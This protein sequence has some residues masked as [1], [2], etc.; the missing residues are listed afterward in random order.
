MFQPVPNQVDFVKQEHEVLDFWKHTDA[1]R[2]LQAKNKG[3][4]RFSFVDGP[5]TANN[6]MGAHHAWG[7]TYKDVFQ[8]YK[9][10]RGFD[11][12]WQNGFDC[13]GLWVEVEV[14]KEQGFKTKRD[15]ET[16]GLAN[17]VNLCKQRVLEYSAVQT[18]Q[19]IRLGYWMD[20]NDTDF[21]RYLKTKMAE[22]PAQVI[23]VDGPN[24]AVTDTVE[25]IVGRLGL[26]ELGGSYFTF[27]NENNYS[28]WTALKQC[29]E[30]GWI[31]KGTDVMPWCARCGTGISQHE[32]ATEGYQELT[33]PS[34]F[35][36][37][38][39]RNRPGEDL[40]VWTTTPWTLSSNVAAAV[41]P[42]LPYVLVEQ[43]PA[44]PI[45]SGA[46]E[47]HRFWLSKRALDNALQGSYTILDEKPGSELEGWTYD[48]P[49][50]ELPAQQASGAVEAHRVVLWDEISEA[51]GTGI[52]HMAPGCGA[53]DYALGRKLGLPAI[54]PLNDAGIFLD[55][56]D[57]LTGMN[58][59]ETA[60]PIFD[61]LKEKGIL[62]RLQD[63][64]HRYPVCWRCQDELVFRLVNEWFIGMG[65]PLDKP[66]E[67]VT[68]DEKADRLRY[69][70]ME[71]V[72]DTRWIPD[73]GFDREM[74]WLRNMHDWM[75]SKKRY[76]GLALPIW[77]CHECGWFDVIGSKE[78]LKARAV[79]G[80][81]EFEGHPPHRPYV[82]AVK[83]RCEN[84][85]A[86]VSRIPDV[87]NPWLDAG[88]VAYSTLGYRTDP[89][90]WR[91]WFPADL[92]TESFPG[93]FRNWF[94]S[95]LA[96]ST[97][98]E[99]KAPFRTVQTYATLFAENGRAMHKSWGNSIEFNDAA[100]TMGVD[101]MRWM[102]CT[103]K[104]EINLLFGY[105]RADET[106]RRFLIPLWNVYSFFVTYANLDGWEP[107]SSQRP[108]SELD[109][110]ILARLNQVVA[111][112]TER[113]DDYDPYGAALVLEPFRDD[114]TNWYVRRSR[115]RFWKS[116]HDADKE[117][118]YATLYHVLLTLCKLLAP[119]AP[120][121]TEVM[122]QNLAHSVDIYQAKRDKD[123]YES[124]HHCD[125]PA[126]DES[127]VDIYQAKRDQNLLDHMAL[128]MQ[129][130]ALGRSARSTSGI[131]LRQPLAR[132]RVY[133]G[134]RAV[135]LDQLTG[136]VTDELNVKALEFVEEEAD[137]VEYEIGLLPNVLGPKHGRRFPLLRQAV[138]DADATALARR[139]QAGLSATLE[140]DDGGP[141]IVL[142]PEEVEIRTHG[143][144]GYTVAEGKG[145]V[146]AVDVTITPE[147]AREGLA[148]DLVRR[149][150]TLRKE[151]NFQL[152]DR[153]VTY[154]DADDALGAVVGQW[155]GYIQAE[156]LSLELVP[157][158]MPDDAARRGSFTLDGH[159]LTL[160]VKKV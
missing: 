116:E 72:Q 49:F 43:G 145:I 56:F 3:H 151:A 55:G 44:L 76:W 140:L 141:A 68:E 54:A 29:H 12:R 114:L 121:V 146:V 65:E 71:A 2:K 69:Q 123:A 150:Q 77:E 46:K 30:N 32:I 93:Q 120:F 48:G 47:G 16:Y 105:H 7:R 124:V 130:D 74:D 33:H 62:Y 26:P 27:S 137:L 36:C 107:T 134:K 125:W 63:Y 84:C 108:I 157:G 119:I 156:T 138:A 39:L 106:R 103:H 128:A 61:N 73:F 154:Y 95:M 5:I 8:R 10:M 148:R 41:H 37:F 9:A 14:E 133:A 79:A 155:G 66:Y 91:R 131:K 6:P 117:A 60:Q 126:A 22:D 160:G 1:F 136:L 78:E 85:G 64:T 58:V 149:I 24:G 35:L 144:E 17:F 100:D 118:A 82:D 109:R 11:Q 13:Q 83:I 99:R 34:V 98:M 53:E 15:I 89:D 90:Y 139:F 94:Y 132:A 115:R 28:I 159:P 152:D 104:P 75:I 111:Q 142:L 70:I 40:L 50:D 81:E 96:M 4:A 59:H 38:P 87:G 42:D 97:I 113:L 127:A 135:D 23:T 153:I 158:P 25:Q 20:W 67:Q 143:R 112:V 147:L 52:V 122:Y 102:Y 21:L 80:W 129:I 88:I 86:T 18:E 57:W 31:Y 19:S 110:W 45:P 101:V 51:E 92:I